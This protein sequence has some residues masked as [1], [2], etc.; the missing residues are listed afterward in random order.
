MSLP[1]SFLEPL[2][3]DCLAAHPADAEKVHL[4]NCELRTHIV[5]LCSSDKPRRESP[6]EFTSLR[7][8]ELGSNSQTT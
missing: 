7:V 6:T 1:R 2:Q 5:L 8:L 3:A 4:S